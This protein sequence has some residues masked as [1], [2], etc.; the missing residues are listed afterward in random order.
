LSSL[1]LTPFS[2]VVLALVGRGGATATEL[3]DMRDRGRIYWTAPRSQWFAEPK[4]LAAAGLL[5]ASTEPGRTGPRTRYRL[6][7]SGRTAVAAWVHE[8][9]GLPRMQHEEI[10]RVLAAD[11]VDDPAD[12]LRGLES[13]RPEIARARA[14]VR[15]GERVAARFGDRAA[16]L[17]VN[18]R[19]AHRILDAL[20]AWLDE[21]EAVLR[22]DGAAPERPA[23]ALAGAREERRS[24]AP[25]RDASP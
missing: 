4:R 3:A 18:H 8:P 11:L 15:E 5:E 10:A 20:E 9:I 24:A 21:V 7:E 14:D 12:V 25:P 19:F 22:P 2:Y 1:R 6:T 13:L 23:A 16:W 17:L